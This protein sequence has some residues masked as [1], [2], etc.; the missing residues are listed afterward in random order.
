MTKTYF[1]LAGL[2]FLNLVFGIY[3]EFGAWDLVLNLPLR[4][5]RPLRLSFFYSCKNQNGSGVQSVGFP[6]NS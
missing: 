2:E 6:M 4:A 5:P 1:I 3:L